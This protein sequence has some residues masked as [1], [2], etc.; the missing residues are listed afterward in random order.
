MGAYDR[1][2][3]RWGM[4]DWKFYN[5]HPS[6]YDKSLWESGK[7]H[8]LGRV[9][10]SQVR[11]SSTDRRHIDQIIKE[12]EHLRG[13]YRDQGMGYSIPSQNAHRAS[14]NPTPTAS[15][16]SQENNPKS[17]QNLNIGYFKKQARRLGTGIFNSA[18]STVSW[19]NNSPNLKAGLVAGGI[20]A[21]GLALI[22]M[23][24]G[25]S[26]E[27]PNHRLRQAEKNRKFVESYNQ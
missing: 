13:H 11:R 1:S 27:K 19:F 17:S 23:T 9:G 3:N 2:Q 10:D 20:L 25:S 7:E 5:E 26:D 16:N 12:S 22:G 4:G 8:L 18:N 15:I 6:L 21:G 24:V 14:I